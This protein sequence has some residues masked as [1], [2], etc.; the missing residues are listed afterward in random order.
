MIQ[1]EYAKVGVPMLPVVKGGQATSIQILLYTLLLLPVT[2]TLVYPL[3]I[4][5]LVYG[6][7]ALG[8]GIWFVVKAVKLCQLK[9]DR[10]YARDVFKY[11][12]LYL[13]LLYT[14]MAIDSLLPY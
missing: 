8:L 13:A 7:A 14:A 10:A 5:G 4:M 6:G 12:V 9:G 11:S 1:D 3:G 2:L